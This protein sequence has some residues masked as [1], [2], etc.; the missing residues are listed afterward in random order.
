MAHI[1]VFS[2]AGAVAHRAAF[3]RGIQRL[4]TLGHGYG[5]TRIIGQLPYAAV[6]R[7]I[8]QGMQWMGFSDFTAFQ[9]G[10]WQA[11]S[12]NK[13]LGLQLSKGPGPGQGTWAGLALL[14]DLGVPEPD[15]VTLACFEDVVSGQSEGTG[16]RLRQS[17]RPPGLQG[18]VQLARSATL[19]GGN[20]SMVVSLMGTAHFPSIKKGVL[21]LED[22]G[23]HPYRIERMLSQLLHSGVLDAQ[24]L[25]VLGQFTQFELQPFDRGFNLRTV[26]QWL[27]SQ[28]R[29]PIVTGLPFGHVATKVCL[30]FGAQVDV[31][32]Q[33][34]DALILWG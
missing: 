14:A 21:F 15:E 4:R 16:W 13:R 20:L 5:I 9:C 6:A 25:I 27:R 30:P 12:R 26:V 34:Q 7:S 22:V 19:W 33:G 29:T 31:A 11:A 3:K 24:Q 28:T 2:P 1:Y 32:L 8:G 18:D 17:D 23:E 10:L